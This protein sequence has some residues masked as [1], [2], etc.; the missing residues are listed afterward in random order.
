MSIISQDIEGVT[1]VTGSKTWK[2]E[3]EMKLRCCEEHGWLFLNAEKQCIKS[4]GNGMLL[5]HIVVGKPSITDTEFDVV[6]WLRL[7]EKT[8]PEDGHTYEGFDE[9]LEEWL[10][11]T[12]PC[13]AANWDDGNDIRCR[14][15]PDERGKGSPHF[16]LDGSCFN[17]AHF[18]VRPCKCDEYFWYTCSDRGYL[19][20]NLSERDR[21]PE[22][23]KESLWCTRVTIPT[24]TGPV[25]FLAY[26]WQMSHYAHNLTLYEN[27]TPYENVTL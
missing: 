22:A 10:E 6:S 16:P 12:G 9:T 3:F 8:C 18:Y 11:D 13:S 1:I 5:S 26:N 24:T 4:H 21:L 2:I 23:H 20:Q 14:W 27:G 15:T 19:P 25:Y 17:I 7:R